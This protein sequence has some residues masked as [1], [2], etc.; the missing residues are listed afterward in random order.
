[1]V[2]RGFGQD[3]EIFYLV[4]SA[5]LVRAAGPLARC[6]SL[7]FGRRGRRLVTTRAL[8]ASDANDAMRERTF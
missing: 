1:M 3:Y 4:T 6:L 7:P 5:L 8:D 2:I